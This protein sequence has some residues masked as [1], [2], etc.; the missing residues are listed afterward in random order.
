M[1]L[2]RELNEKRGITIFLVTHEPDVAKNAKRIVTFRDGH[3]VSD[4]AASEA[5]LR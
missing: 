1:N 3:I 5:V 4:V 2:F